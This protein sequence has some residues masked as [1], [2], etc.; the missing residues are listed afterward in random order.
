MSSLRLGLLPLDDRPCNLLFPRRIAQI[1]GVRLVVP[2]RRLLGRFTAPGDAEALSDWLQRM[3][4]E[5][6][7][8]IVS[9]D[10]LAYGGLVASRTGVVPERQALARINSLHRIRR[11]HPDLTIFCF[12][13]IMRL[14]I[15]V[16]SEGAAL[17]HERIAR[18]AQLTD[19]VRRLRREEYADEL[20]R[21][22][23]L[24]P[25]RARSSYMRIRRRNHAANMW[26]VQLVSDGVIDYLVLAQEDAAARGLHKFEQQMLSD[27]MASLGV[28]G[29]V[30]LHPGT[31][32]VAMVLLARY[33]CRQHGRSPAVLPLYP[34]RKAEAVIPLFE[35]RPLRETVTA[36]IQAAGGRVAAQRGEADLVLVVHAPLSKQREARDAGKH[37]TPARVVE[38]AVGHIKSA[39]RGKPVA[40]A[41]VAYCNGA[42]PALIQALQR[43]RL[44][45][46]LHAFAGWNTAGNSIGAA[47]AHGIARVF[48]TPTHRS[49]IAHRLFLFERLLDDY[50]YQSIIRQQAI[51]RAERLGLSPLNLGGKGRDLQ[52]FVARRAGPMAR[53]L[54][55][56]NFPG[57]PPSLGVRLPWPRLFEAEIRCSLSREQR[58]PDRM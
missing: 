58:W 36:Q 56:R 14:G 32:E 21:L 53:S 31:D 23:G 34:S 7:G 49:E 33:L 8:L 29:R 11:A 42:D 47:V 12:S 15:T 55:R 39:L 48:S 38:A 5:V 51:S 28:E 13:V 26:A 19:D 24:I 43:E 37:P 16:D 1:A 10:M 54:W 2:P 22:E 40:V 25:P 57:D 52:R 45:A 35:D 41:D 44:F 50:A 20:I 6:E 46:R 27:G 3:A 9:A 4:G 18:W 17:L 30:S